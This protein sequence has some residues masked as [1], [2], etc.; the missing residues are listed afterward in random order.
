LLDEVLRASANSL[1]SWAYL[2]VVERP[3]H[4][5]EIFHVICEGGSSWLS[6]THVYVMFKTSFH[7]ILLKNSKTFTALCVG[8]GFAVA[9]VAGWILFAAVVGYHLN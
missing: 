7:L 6:T 5:F 4:T 8:T 2:T 1:I 3:D 9:F